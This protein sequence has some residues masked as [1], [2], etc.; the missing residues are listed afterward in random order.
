MKKM[1]SRVYVAVVLAVAFLMA[2]PAVAAFANGDQARGP[3]AI[4][5]NNHNETL[6]RG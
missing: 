6:L 1:L 3:H 4:L 5:S 2:I